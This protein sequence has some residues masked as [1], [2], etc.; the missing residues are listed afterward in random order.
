MNGFNGYRGIPSGTGETAA[1]AGHP[2]IVAILKRKIE[3][4]GPLPFWDYMKICLYHPE[5]GY[6]RREEP[7]IGRDGDFYTSSNLGSVMGEIIAGELLAFA[8]SAPSGSPVEFVEFGGGT[9]RLARQAL[10]A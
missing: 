7:K 9:G 2:E 10:D 3:E 4:E 1:D 8:E 5:F 6:Y